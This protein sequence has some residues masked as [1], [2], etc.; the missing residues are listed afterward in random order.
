MKN[1][2]GC[3]T[4]MLQDVFVLVGKGLKDL[5]TEIQLSVDPESLW[6]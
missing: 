4:N 6:R 1:L 2:S 5:A 3:D